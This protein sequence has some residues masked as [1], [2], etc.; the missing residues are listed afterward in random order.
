MWRAEWRSARDA[1][2]ARDGLAETPRG[3]GVS[4]KNRVSA[5]RRCVF[6]S[7]PHTRDVVLSINCTLPS[8]SWTLP[9][10]AD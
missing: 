3:A 8:R 7:R 1:M 9:I 6:L 5:S 4:F 2:N 10:S